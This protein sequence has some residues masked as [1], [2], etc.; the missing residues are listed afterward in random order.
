MLQRCT[1]RKT[2]VVAAVLFLSGL[3]TILVAAQKK[4]QAAP[5]LPEELKGAKVYRLPEETKSGK[6]AE[7]PVIYRSFSYQD[8]N[9]E[10]LVLNLYVG[11]KQVDRAAT[12]RRMYFQDVRASG[13]PL[14]I[15]TFDQEFKLSKKG[16]VDLPA[17]LKCTIVF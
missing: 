14:H 5:E 1:F 9:L 15:E 16:A 6:P 7:N 13:I 4:E 2:R 3:G 10:R 8:I 11:I 12:V 17:P